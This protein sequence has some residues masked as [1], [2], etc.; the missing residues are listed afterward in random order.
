MKYVINSAI[1]INLKILYTYNIEYW[2]TIVLSVVLSSAY[3]CFRIFLNFD[4]S[5]NFSNRGT[6]NSLNNRVNAPV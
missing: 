4:T 3:D 6:R 5:I 1:I 2:N